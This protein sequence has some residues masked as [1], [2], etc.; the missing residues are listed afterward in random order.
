MEPN[1]MQVSERRTAGFLPTVWDPDLIIS[2][3]TGYKYESHTTRLEQL[4]QATKTLLESTK[5]APPHVLLSLIDAIHR[6][7]VA[8][9]FEEE[10][11]EALNNLLISM[12][13]NDLFTVALYFRLSRQNGLSISSEVF[14]KFLGEDGKFMDNLREDL[15]GILSLYEASYLGI[16]GEDILEEANNFSTRHLKSSL[17]QILDSNI[18]EQVQLSLEIPVHQRL[19][20]IEARN[21]INVYQR[22][23]S[24]SL[25][26]LELAKL[27]YNIVQSLYL[28]ELK[29]LAGWWKDMNFKEKYP[30]SRDR[31]VEGYF[32]SMGCV[33][34]PQFSKCRKSMAKLTVVAT[35]LDDIYDV[36]G[37]LDELE[38]LTDAISCWD[39]KVVEDLPEYMRP[40]YIAIH[41]HVEEMVEDAS[42]RLGMDILPYI[43]Q[44][45]AIYTRGYMEESRWIYSGY[46]PTFDEY[47]ENGVRTI[48]APLATTYAFFGTLDRDTIS[49]HSL[50][51]IQSPDSEF[52]YLAA[53]IGRLYDDLQTS[54]DEMERG[55]VVNAIK[56]YMVQERVSEEEARDH[57]KGLISDAWKKLNGLIASKSLPECLS[58]IALNT[59]RCWQHM[60]KK[61]DWFSVQSEAHRDTII[62]S[63]L[64]PIP[65]EQK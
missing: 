29:E 23:K 19:P 47:L 56:C 54:E 7:G 42:E 51:W 36:Y 38:R 50:E 37:H 43:K 31:L 35:V 32:Y 14:N 5:D 33:P 59:G 17:M 40:C 2:S 48:G 39:L 20:W 13:P 62:S 30:F 10:I 25:L 45:W 18:S 8:Y 11:K 27:D 49:K 55:E 44:N 46:I 22:D 57:I 26:L 9:H 16:G 60:Y 6:L 58:V 61:G 3:S 21:F 12:V 34:H 28:E 63:F 1:A 65:M 64:E 4:K 24:K 15:K 52:L 53:L 41:E